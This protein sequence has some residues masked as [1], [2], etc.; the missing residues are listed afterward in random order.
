[1]SA[2][3]TA[4]QA[5]TTEEPQSNEPTEVGKDIEGQIGQTSEGGSLELPRESG[6]SKSDT[7]QPLRNSLDM[8]VDTDGTDV[9]EGLDSGLPLESSSPQTDQEDLTPE[10]EDVGE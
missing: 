6:S 3:P 9:S 2:L 1:M 8:D 5:S 4:T 10:Q 7:S